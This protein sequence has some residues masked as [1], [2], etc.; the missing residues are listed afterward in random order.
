MTYKGG[1]PLPN[2]PDQIKDSKGIHYIVLHHSATDMGWTI[3]DFVSHRL[4][5]GKAGGAKSK[6][7][8]LGYNYVLLPLEH[9]IVADVPENQ[10]SWSVALF[11]SP[12]LSICTAGYFHAPKNDH[13]TDA[14]IDLLA[15][16]CAE[17]CLKYHL[18]P[19]K[20]IIG[21]RDT[22]KI[23]K[24]PAI[25]TACPGDLLYARL[26]DVRTKAKAIIDQMIIPHM[27]LERGE[28]PLI[29]ELHQDW[30]DGHNSL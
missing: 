23:T 1:E 19:M 27:A 8:G 9:R 20:A 5:T 3:N 24:N 26:P 14:M 11:N 25:A 16:K 18:D 12:S 13:P 15:H 30:D 29:S 21:H 10:V 17:L 2:K 7:G 6:Y 28:L 22:S 4:E